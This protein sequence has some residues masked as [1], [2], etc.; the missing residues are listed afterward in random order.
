[1]R[2]RFALSARSAT[3]QS[4]FDFVKNCG[5]EPETDFVFIQTMRQVRIRDD[6]NNCTVA[7]GVGNEGADPFNAISDVEFCHSDECE[8]PTASQGRAKFSFVM[9]E[10]VSVFLL[11]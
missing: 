5:I 8:P 6:A 10:V 7:H 1:M 9:S 3:Y 4:Q 11:V 2:A